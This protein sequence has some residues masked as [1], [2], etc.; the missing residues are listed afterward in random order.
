[1]NTRR[2]WFGLVVVIC[3]ALFLGIL[4]GCSD[5][6]STNPS[7]QTESLRIYELYVGGGTFTPL[8]GDT[9]GNRFRLKVGLFKT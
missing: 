8:P 1:M 7:G 2:S 4:A 6:D 3:F 9:T 5:N